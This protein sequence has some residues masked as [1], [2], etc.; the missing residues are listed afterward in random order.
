MEDVVGGFLGHQRD[1][2]AK[3]SRHYVFAFHIDQDQFGPLGNTR[4]VEQLADHLVDVLGHVPLIERDAD[5]MRIVQ[6]TANVYVKV[7]HTFVG[8]PIAGKRERLDFI[9]RDVRHDLQVSADIVADHLANLVII[10]TSQLHTAKCVL[11]LL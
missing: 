6:D 8:G 1:K 2:S 11:V 5:D 9:V 7:R 3:P 4:M 10:K